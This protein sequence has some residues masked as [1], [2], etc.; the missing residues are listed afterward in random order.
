[1]VWVIGFFVGRVLSRCAR[2][3]CDWTGPATPHH[4]TTNHQPSTPPEHTDQTHGWVGRKDA[5]CW[6]GPS[7]VSVGRVSVLDRADAFLFVRS[8]GSVSGR[9]FA[10]AC[11]VCCPGNCILLGQD[12]FG[13]DDG[14][15]VHSRGSHLVS[16]SGAGGTGGKGRLADDNGIPSATVVQSSEG[17][18]SIAS[19]PPESIDAHQQKVILA[20]VIEEPNRQRRLSLSN[21]QT[22]NNSQATTRLS[23]NA[24]K[25]STRV[26]MVTLSSN[27]ARRGAR[28][29]T[30]K[31][32]DE[33]FPRKQ[34]RASSPMDQRRAN[35]RSNSPPPAVLIEPLVVQNQ[36]HQRGELLNASP[37]RS[38]VMIDDFQH[39]TA[40]MS[41]SSPEHASL[42]H[43]VESNSN[44]SAPAHHSSSS[45]SSSKPRLIN[46]RTVPAME[47]SFETTFFI[48]PTV[49]KQGV[50]RQ[51]LLAASA[52]TGV[53]VA[54]H[55]HVHPLSRNLPT[56]KV[57]V[58]NRIAG[59]S[60]LEGNISAELEERDERRLRYR[61]SE[62]SN[63]E[64]SSNE[65]RMPHDSRTTSPL[66]QSTAAAGEHKGLMNTSAVL[67]PLPEHAS[68]SPVLG[69][70]QAK[71]AHKKNTK[72]KEK[73]ALSPRKFDVD[74]SASSMI[75]VRSPISASHPD[76]AEAL[77]AMAAA[78]AA[79]AAA[80]LP[81]HSQAYPYGPSATSVVQPILVERTSSFT[82]PAHLLRA[83][84]SFTNLNGADGALSPTGHD[85]MSPR[86][87]VVSPY[88]YEI[89][90]VPHNSE[91]TSS[92]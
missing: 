75:T 19:S 17:N 7:R 34:D 71:L 79:C 89:A 33:P 52:L 64:P 82:I 62:S 20:K 46:I 92:C 10:L 41:K 6:V 2:C 85:C 37:D 28:S 3:G 14:G 25:K 49:A 51:H 86:E 56:P 90:N 42:P 11:D 81:T 55:Q 21:R 63:T 39:Q 83:H 58:E 50:P 80:P 31:I 12:E 54:F 74:H 35:H 67:S 87:D 70:I 1:M 8:R 73:R 84:R 24:N 9:M 15:G 4:T 45:P 53:E 44:S 66:V 36:L 60:I 48:P 57:V 22:T 69:S 78:Q 77:A 40:N 26:T 27:S 59:S 13:V 76:I 32:S 16:V 68:R 18:S 88:T 72:L 65:G 61:D 43:S 5:T 30:N 23:A 29:P 91:H 38:L 47:P